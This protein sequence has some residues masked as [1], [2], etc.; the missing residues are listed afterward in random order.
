[1]QCSTHPNRKA[2]AMCMNC[3][4]LVCEECAVKF[5]GKNYCTQCVTPHNYNYDTANNSTATNSNYQYNNQLQY[6]NTSSYSNENCYEYNVQPSQQQQQY[7][8]QQTTSLYCNDY[9]PRNYQNTNNSS[10]VAQSQAYSNNLN[11]NTS[12]QGFSFIKLLRNIPFLLSAIVIILGVYPAYQVLFLD[13]VQQ[14]DIFASSISDLSHIEKILQRDMLFYF[15]IPAT[16]FLLISLMILFI[17]KRNLRMISCSVLN[18]PSALVF[19]F[20]NACAIDHY[21]SYTRIYGDFISGL[22]YLNILQFVVGFIVVISLI[23]P[24]LKY[25]SDR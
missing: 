18:V 24:F 10:Y 23:M 7:S 17:D 8:Q 16:L 20:F 6:D 25:P 5:E 3:R 14:I 1:M 19:L 11:T 12:S 9:E 13:E 4:C 2:I 22:N 15:A 21:N